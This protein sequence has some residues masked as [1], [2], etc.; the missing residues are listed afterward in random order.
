MDTVRSEEASLPKLICLADGIKPELHSQAVIDKQLE[1][2][3]AQPS[4]YNNKWVHFK[5]EGTLPLH[6]VWIIWVLIPHCPCLAKC[7][8]GVRCKSGHDEGAGIYGRRCEGCSFFFQTSGW[9]RSS[10]LDTPGSGW[11]V[12][13]KVSVYVCMYKQVHMSWRTHTTAR[14]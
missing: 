14:P 6:A 9:E 7:L 12:L 5:W 11:T 4:F 1:R 2:P 13:V 10:R 8:S 3:K